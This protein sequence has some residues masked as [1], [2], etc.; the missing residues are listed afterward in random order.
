MILWAHPS[1]QPKRHLD[2]FSHLCRDD[3]IV[4]LYLTIGRP[5]PIKIAPSL[6]DLD[7]HLIHSFLG[8]PESSTK[9]H[10]DR[11]NRFCRDEKMEAERQESTRRWE[12]DV[13]GRQTD[14][15]TDHAILGR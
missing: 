6:R 14:R 4:S 7:P 11:C 10:L 9:W 12:A 13:T 5:F 8:P 2:Q 1:P 3:R 15:P